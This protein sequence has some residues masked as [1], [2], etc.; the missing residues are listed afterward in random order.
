MTAA[1]A[2]GEINGYG[3]ETV[4]REERFIDR[5]QDEDLWWLI[6]FRKP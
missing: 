1:L 4:T 2:E 6:A 3:F 5:L